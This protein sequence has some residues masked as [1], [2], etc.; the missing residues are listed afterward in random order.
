MQ[1]HACLDINSDRDRDALSRVPRGRIGI[2]LR[3]KLPNPS[4]DSKSV[5]GLSNHTV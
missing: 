4:P 3:P 5:R 1:G 2:R